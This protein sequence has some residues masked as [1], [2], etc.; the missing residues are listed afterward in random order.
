[1][2]KLLIRTCAAIAALFAI[3]ILCYGTAKSNQAPSAVIEGDWRAK[4]DNDKIKFQLNYG[5]PHFENNTNISMNIDKSDIPNFVYDKE[6]TFQ[7]KRECGTMAFT[8]KFSESKGKG[9]FEFTIN[10]DFPKYLKDLGFNDL[11]D[12]DFVLF[13]AFD[14]TKDYISGLKKLGY[15]D[16]SASKLTS[17]AIFDVNLDF[18]KRIHEAGFKDISA[19]KLI[20]FRIFKVTPEYIKEIEAAGIKNLKPQNLVDFKI[21]KITNKFIEKVKEIKK[22]KE[23]TAGYIV[24]A[25][26][27][28][29]RITDDDEY[30]RD[31]DEDDN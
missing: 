2:Q 25:K 30:E 28:G 21:F 9:E 27:V 18:I 29:I 19:Q 1:M 22:N 31:N 3:T 7:L 12:H 16:L 10:D 23:L 24:N 5:Q 15:G 8:G 4:I 11:K 26:I 20:D 17:F 14:I 13:F 6:F